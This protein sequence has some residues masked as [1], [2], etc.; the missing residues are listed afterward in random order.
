MLSEHVRNG[1]KRWDEALDKLLRGG[2]VGRRGVE[3]ETTRTSYQTLVLTPV[4]AQT[5][6]VP[7][8]KDD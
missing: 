7:V 1:E 5:L 3:R 6:G 4:G 8:R 2:L